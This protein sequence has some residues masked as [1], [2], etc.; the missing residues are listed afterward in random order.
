MTDR[1]ADCPR[2]GRHAI[3]HYSRHRIMCLTELDRFVTCADAPV[4]DDRERAIRRWNSVAGR[5]A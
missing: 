2:C 3:Y 5:K 1:I 4:D